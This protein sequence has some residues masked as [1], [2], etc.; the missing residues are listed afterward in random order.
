MVAVAALIDL[1]ISAF[2]SLNKYT[3]RHDETHVARATGRRE[4]KRKGGRDSWSK[5]CDH[6]AETGTRLL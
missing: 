2:V 1:E 3:T 4:R 6:E 5:H